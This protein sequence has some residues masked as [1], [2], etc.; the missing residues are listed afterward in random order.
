MKKTTKRKEPARYSPEWLAGRI[1]QC[2]AIMAQ[3][4][5]DIAACDWVGPKS[6]STA[7]NIYGASQVVARWAREIRKA[8]KAGTK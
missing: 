1:D 5:R 8:A 6:K 7:P 4:A 3:T 2:S